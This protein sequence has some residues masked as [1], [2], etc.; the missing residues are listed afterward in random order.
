VKHERVTWLIPVRNGARYL[1]ATL[2]SIAAQTYPY[3]QVLAWDNGSTDG[4][5][6]I[7][8]RWIGTRLTGRV[9]SDQPL[10]LGASLARL[11]E[12]APTELCARIDADDI[13]LPHRLEM[14][15]RYMLAHRDVA[16]LGTQVHVIDEHG[17]DAPRQWSHPCG[18]A[19][20]R[21]RMRVASAMMHPTV[22]FR[23]SAIL[24]VGNY[25]DMLPGQDYD[26]WLRVA[27]KHRVANLSEQLVQ[28]R[29]H[30]ATVSHQSQTRGHVTNRRLVERYVTNLLPGITAEDALRLHSLMTT[31]TSGRVTWRDVM[32]LRRTA[33]HAAL[34]TGESPRYFRRTE[35]YR[36]QWRSLL[37]RC[38]RQTLGL[39]ATTMAADL[40]SKATDGTSSNTSTAADSVAGRRAA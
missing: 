6:D 32:N 19:E 3:Q 15:V 13:N 9:I 38:V 11:V 18:D 17:N 12:L 33:T 8:R 5:L 10:G 22:M 25:R 29:K 21:W 36:Q 2:A 16:L 20:I 37:G 27:M 28:Y 34:H 39:R 23:R 31:N 40:A 30:D 7:L 14:Q 35:R 24:G 26:L 4:T 1:E